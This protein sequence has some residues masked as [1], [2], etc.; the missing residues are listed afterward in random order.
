MGIAAAQALNCQD[1]DF[2]C[3][4]DD[5]SAYRFRALP[6]GAMTSEIRS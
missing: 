6:D 4:S 1:Q 5:G 3:N 2:A